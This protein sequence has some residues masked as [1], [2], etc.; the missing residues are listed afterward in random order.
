VLVGII[1]LHV[2]AVAEA[3]AMKGPVADVEVEAAPIEAMLLQEPR[4]ARP[5][6]TRVQPPEIVVPQMVVPIVNI[7]LPDPPAPMISV[8][9]VARPAPDSAPAPAM[10]PVSTPASAGDADTPVAVSMADWVRMPSPVYPPAARQ[11]RAQGVVIVLALVDVTGHAVSAVVHRSSGFAALDRAACESV[12][13]ALFRPYQHNGVP[14]SKNVTVP[15]TF[16]WR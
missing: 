4:L 14:R 1:V 7:E 16:E 12:R 3:L 11:A 6:D 9:E 13:A 5:P 10:A 2:A 15:I 8:V